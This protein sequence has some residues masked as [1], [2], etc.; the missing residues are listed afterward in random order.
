MTCPAEP[1]ILVSW[2]PELGHGWPMRR[3]SGS[4]NSSRA[5]IR[6][7]IGRTSVSDL[8]HHFAPHLHVRYIFCTSPQK[9]YLY[10][11]RQIISTLV[12]FV[13]DLWLL[14]HYHLNMDN[15]CAGLSQPVLG[16]GPGPL[17]LG[18]I[19]VFSLKL[20]KRNKTYFFI[21]TRRQPVQARVHL[22]AAEFKETMTL[23]FFSKH[24]KN[25]A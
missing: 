5:D 21:H 17:E 4:T 1:P 18:K 11:A 3:R 12:H 2:I 25:N 6:T 24:C 14:K 19:A 23:I 7:D 10:H 15:S 20:E 16:L 9:C 22:T 13:L 8:L